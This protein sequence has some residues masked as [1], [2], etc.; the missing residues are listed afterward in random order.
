VVG[1]KEVAL[2]RRGAI[3][4]EGIGKTSR[5]AVLRALRAAG[6]RTLP[7]V[8]YDKIVPGGIRVRTA[9]GSDLTIAADTVVIAAG[10]QRND[11]LLEPIRAL[12]VPFRVVGGAKDA[13]ELNA[14]R[15]FEEGLRAAHELAATLGNRNL[16]S[17]S[18]AEAE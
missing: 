11:S 6:V 5:W 12:G 15:A 3:I 9:D 7:N 13:S 10:Q 18:S 1:R 4:G 8:S 14:V 2:M 17:R 16:R